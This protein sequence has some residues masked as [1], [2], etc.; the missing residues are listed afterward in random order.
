MN[1]VDVNL[2]NMY[3]G[4]SLGNSEANRAGFRLRT[5]GLHVAERGPRCGTP[6]HNGKGQYAQ[7]VKDLQRRD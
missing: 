7:T 6:Y 2:L 1:V 3:E 4:F 5:P